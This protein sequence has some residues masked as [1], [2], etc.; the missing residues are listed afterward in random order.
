LN[1]WILAGAQHVPPNSLTVVVTN[2]AFIEAAV[3]GANHEMARELLWR[4]VPSDPRGTVFTHFWS[5]EAI[6]PVHT[7]AGD[8]G[9]NLSPGGSPL[10][11]IVIRSPLL[12]RYPNAVVFAVQGKVTND[13]VGNPNFEPDANAAIAKVLY[14]G[15]ITPDLT[16]SV[17]NLT[18]ENAIDVNQHWYLVLGEPVSEPRFGLDATADHGSDLVLDA[19]SELAWSDVP[20]AVRLSPEERPTPAV[21]GGVGWGTDAAAMA[22]ILHQDPFRL[23]MKATDFLQ[24]GA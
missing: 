11:A 13:N 14:T 8:L 4:D 19:W 10:V 21:I 16:Y 24:G 15:A 6:A 1:S 7:W 20:N 3:A 12:R 23:V 5:T 17:I 22:H 18:L 2:P 9:S